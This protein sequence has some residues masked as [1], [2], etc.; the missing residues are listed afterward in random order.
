MATTEL[1]I[2]LPATLSQEEAK[3]LL[4]VKLFEVGKASL[5][6]AAKIAELSKRTFMEILGRY[7]IPV[8]NYSPEELRTEVDF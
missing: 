2:E 7:G 8:S 4:A 3:L 6:Q 5:G 1:R